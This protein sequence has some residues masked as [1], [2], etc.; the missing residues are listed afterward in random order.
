MIK[1]HHYITV[2]ASAAPLGGRRLSD[3]A[4]LCRRLALGARLRC[5]RWAQRS[6]V[7]VV[8]VVVIILL[9]LLLLLVGFGRRRGA[10]LPLAV[11]CAVCPSAA[12]D[13]ASGGQ[14]SLA[15]LPSGP[16]R[17]SCCSCRRERLGSALAPGLSCG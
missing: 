2:T 15:R 1:Y 5:R 14:R 13:A 4:G 10:A 8:V 3:S 7:V 11:R 16:S 6:I 9:Q 12:G 17:A